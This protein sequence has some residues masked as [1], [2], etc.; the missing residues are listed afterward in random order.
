[1][2]KERVKKSFLSS[3]ITLM[4]ILILVK[5]I[6]FIK[7]IILA[8]V[9]GTSFQ[10]DVYYL[11]SGFVGGVAQMLFGAISVAVLPVYTNVL[12][13]KGR[14]DA[15][16]YISKVIKFSIV[17]GCAMAVV[18]LLTSELISPLLAPSYSSTQLV[19]VNR[20]IRI[21]VVTVFFF[22]LSNIYSVVL[23]VEKVF[24]PFRISGIIN[25]ISFIAA[26]LLFVKPFGD[27]ALIIAALVSWLLQLINVYYFARKYFVYTGNYKLKNIFHDADIKQLVFL[28][29][30]MLIG[31]AIVEINDIVDKTIST[32]LTVG[33]LSALSYAQILKEFV[34]FIFVTSLGGVLF[35]YIANY[36]A[37][38][39]HELVA[40][41]LNKVLRILIMVL[42]PVSIYVFIYAKDIVMVAYL[43]GNFSMDAV[44]LCAD[45]L[46]GYALGFCFMAIR[47]CLIK[48]HYAYQDTKI[49]LFN[50]SIA[51]LSNIVLCITLSKFI[52]ILGVTVATSISAL[53]SGVLSLHSVKRHNNQISLFENRKSTIQI[54]TATVLVIL[55]NLIP[56][57]KFHEGLID[58][59]TGLVSVFGLYFVVLLLF[60]NE[61]MYYFVNLLMEKVKLKK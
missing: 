45:S 24:V 34:I 22:C 23:D 17:L 33:A 29:I 38:Q 2:E 59:I 28:F 36:I 49:P 6:G 9:F 46:K 11:T 55:I 3:Q 60:K 30:P 58:M 26:A 15:N 10:V 56:A 13:R 50:G 19:S 31:N 53:I 18:L 7:Q 16:Q 41:F 43:R 12:V 21:F 27:Q 1:M 39:K 52:G 57:L 47:E 37:E 61:E 4:W 44:N 35:S 14:D 54:I 8:A 32:G 40:S 20:D 42:S 25:S 48:T 51:V 5:V